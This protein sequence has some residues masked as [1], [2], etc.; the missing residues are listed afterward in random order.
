MVWLGT[1]LKLQEGLAASWRLERELA[2][3][4]QVFTK[5]RVLLDRFAR[6]RDGDFYQEMVAEEMT[7][8]RALRVR[9]LRAEV[10]WTWRRIGDVLWDEWGH[11]PG[12]HDI[13]KALCHVAKEYLKSD[14][15]W[16]G[17]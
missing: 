2:Q 14:E 17:D 12:G 10:H 1:R 5:M 8:D 11:Y 4:E 13:G 15:D 3:T 16:D 6:R 7:W 9:H